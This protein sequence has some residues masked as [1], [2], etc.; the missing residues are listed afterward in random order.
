MPT[1]SVKQVQVLIEAQAVTSTFRFRPMFQL[2]TTDTDEPDA[3]DDFGAVLSTDGLHT[4]DLTDLESSD[5]IQNA[6]FIRF[7]VLGRSTT[8][9]TWASGEIT[10]T[11]GITSN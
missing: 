11:F 7:G 3:W 4:V 10:A 2:A 1:A 9:A 5:T 6:Y 8:N